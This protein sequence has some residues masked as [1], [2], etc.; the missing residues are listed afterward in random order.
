MDKALP[1]SPEAVLARLSQQGK[2][3]N[4]NARPTLSR[5]QKVAQAHGGVQLH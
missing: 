3:A 1:S 2:K 5:A 4:P